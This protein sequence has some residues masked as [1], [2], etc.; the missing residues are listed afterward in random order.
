MNAAEIQKRQMK[1]LRLLAKSA[2]Y[3]ADQKLPLEDDAPGLPIAGFAGGTRFVDKD[4]PKFEGSTE[5]SYDLSCLMLAQYIQPCYLRQSRN[6]IGGIVE[7]GDALR[8]THEGI[9]QVHELERSWFARAVEKQP[10]TFLLVIV[11]VADALWTAALAY[12]TWW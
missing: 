10:F 3:R 9:S 12:W 4:D 11:A 1:L 8:L 7:E 2:R 5:Q 6:S